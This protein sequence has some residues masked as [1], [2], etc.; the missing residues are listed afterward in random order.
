VVCHGVPSAA[1]F[2]SYLRWQ[3]AVHGAPAV[4]CAFRDKR[5]GWKRYR[6]VVELADGREHAV[7]FDRDPFM[8]GF[9]RNLYLRP[10]CHLCTYSRVPRIGDLTLG[11]FWGVRAVD[12]ALDDDRGTSLV[13]VSSERGRAALESVAGTLR[14]SER[15]LAEGVAANPCVVRPVARPPERDR[16]FADFAARPFSEVV[17][18]W[19]EPPP[20]QR[21]DPLRGLRRLARKLGA[22][23]VR[24][25]AR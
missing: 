23:V 2:R 9:L 7:A 3:E 13:L 20:Q 14:L 6:V 16:F 11:D 5:G 17:R 4:A 15:A 12:R 19:L 21:K 22:A 10:S 18:R 25:R 24:R 1:V 8:L